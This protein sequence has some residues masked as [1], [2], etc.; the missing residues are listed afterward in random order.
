MLTTNTWIGGK[1]SFLG[2]YLLLLG[3]L[4]IIACLS[5]VVVYLVRPPTGSTAKLELSWQSQGSAAD[6][7]ASRQ[8]PPAR[9]TSQRVT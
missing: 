7:D 3:S 4:Y 1:N 9:S 2:I 5:F 8:A 6:T